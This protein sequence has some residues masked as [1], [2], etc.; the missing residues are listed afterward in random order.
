LEHSLAPGYPEDP[1]QTPVSMQSPSVDAVKAAF[2]AVDPMTLGLEEEAMLLD[3]GSLDL[4]PRAV[5]VV[6]RAGDPRFKLELPAAQVEIVLPPTATVGESAAALGSAR[7]DLAIAAEG[8]VLAAAGAHPFADPLGALNDGPRHAPIA[9]AF[10]GVARMQLVCALQVHVAVGGHARTLAV[11]NALRS[12]LPE[13]AAL[14]ANAPFYAGRDTGL[15]SV[16]PKLCELLP[17]QGVPPAIAS[18]EAYVEAMRWG[19]RAGA[20]PAPARWW[21]E[22]RPHIEHGT[23]ELR[24]PDA[25]ATVA[26]AAAVAAVAHALVGWLAARHDAGELPE[27][28][29]TWRIEE[30]RWA[31]CRDGM[32][33]EFA[34][35][36]TG[37]RTPVRDLL[38]ARLEQL[39]PTARALG[40]AAEL[41]DAGRLAEAGGAAR[42]RIA[43]AGD[44]RAAARWLAGAYVP[45]A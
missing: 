36:R 41:A 4:C 28:D 15:A 22:L 2:E 21:W 44:P 32:E 40:C 18:W 27:P 37:Q 17:R 3:P 1:L 13:L 20:L 8:I 34:D 11:Y 16:R 43:A 42:Q 10:G 35:L 5:E 9:D 38:A 30:N 23:L 25:Q 31:A 33:A 24:V 6:A 12:F 14:A 26:D 45:G 19:A 39:A 29:P 7:R